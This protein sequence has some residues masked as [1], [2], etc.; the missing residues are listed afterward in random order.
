MARRSPVL[1]LFGAGD[2][3]LQPVYV[4]DVGKAVLRVLTTPSSQGKV[5][6]LGGPQ[7]YRYRA[8]I[9]LLLKEASQSRILLPLPFFAWD[10]LARLL[11]LLP[12]PPLTT[13]VVTL[14]RRDNVV[15]AGVQTFADLGLSPTAVEP[16]LHVMLGSRS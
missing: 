13:D 12:N 9:E 11:M 6:E 14:M 15:D 10:A 5:Y 16:I 8:L 2:T 1:A 4:D 3:R 7:I